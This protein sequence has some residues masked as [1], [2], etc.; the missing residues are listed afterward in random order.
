MADKPSIYQLR[1]DLDHIQPPIWRRFL[2]PASTTLGMMHLIIQT[3]MGWAGYHLHEFRAGKRVFGL[4]DPD[5]DMHVWDAG[6]LIDEQTVTLAG[7]LARKGSK[8][9]YLYDFG[10]GWEHTLKLEAKLP[11]EP[12]QPYP[13]CVAGERSAPPEDVGGPWGY[14]HFLGVMA[15]PNHPEHEERVEWIGSFDPEAF[16]IDEVNAQL[17]ALS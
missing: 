5:S 7:V 16:D 6:N 17:R 11:V 9:A 4:T 1:I 10:D 3:T 14:I 2:V 8:L 15:D 13:V 12:G